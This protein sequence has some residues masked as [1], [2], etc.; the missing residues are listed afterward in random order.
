MSLKKVLSKHLKL[1]KT[2]VLF[3]IDNDII[4]DKY[5]EF[6]IDE[7][8]I[9]K[10]VLSKTQTSEKNISVNLIKLITKSPENIKKANELRVLGS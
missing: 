8:Y 2:P 4:D 6:I 10:I 1:D 7:N 3:Q 5:D 9:L